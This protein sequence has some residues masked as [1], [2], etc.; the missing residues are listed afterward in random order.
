VTRRVLLFRPSMADGG[1]DRVTLTVLR[2]L[3][4]ERFT[5]SLALMRLEGPLLDELPGDVAVH[6]VRAPRLALAAPSLAWLL[7]QHTPDVLFSTSST[8]NIVAA[9]A[10]L[11]ARSR[12]RL[13]LSERTPLFRAGVR[14]AR[15]RAFA[16]AKRQSYRRADLVT[17]VAAGVAE[18]LVAELGLP[19]ERVR[20]LDNPMIDEELLSQAAEPV[21]HPFFAGGPPVVLACGR[22]VAVKDYPTLL[23]AFAEVRRAQPA[24]LVVLGDG[25]E[26]AALEA[27]VHQ[28]G[29]RDDV[30][31][32]GFDKNPFRYM[33][34][35]ALLLHA[36]RA[37]GMPGAQI[38]AMACGAPVVSTDCEFGPREVI[39]DGH[40]GYLVPVGDAAALAERALRVLRDAALRDRLAAA[41]RHSV[42][43]FELS[44]AMAGYQQALEAG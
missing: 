2:H 41:A 31:L 30:W 13:V 36:S 37:E 24:R 39:R 32:V 10:H 4:R 9:M 42:A 7:Q 8:G 11:A 38:Q 35:A 27:Q 19:P 3:D 26:R 23:R 1:A 15:N 14:D 43:R 29:L 6:Q 16:W 34:K 20:V 28:I 21:A 12:A 5:P 40:N 33:A 17:A 25:P 18:Q 22:M 44:R